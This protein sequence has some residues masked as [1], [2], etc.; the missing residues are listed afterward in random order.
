MAVWL[1][2]VKSVLPPVW[3]FAELQSDIDCVDMN[4]LS[5]SAPCSPIVYLMIH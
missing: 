4:N 5:S 1:C 3:T 2:I